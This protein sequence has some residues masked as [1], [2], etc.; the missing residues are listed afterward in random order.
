M[1]T[2]LQ[3]FFV[4]VLLIL[5][6][7]FVYRPKR[8]KGI[9][10]SRHYL[11]SVFNDHVKFYQLL[12]EEDKKRFEE[13]VQNFL[14]DIRITGVKTI[15]EDIDR[16]FIGAGAIIPVY[17]F[18]D[19]EYTNLHEI[20]LYPG[21]FSEEFEQEGYYRSISGMVGTG[22]MQNV[23]IISKADLRRSF[24]DNYGTRNTAIH[25]FVH[26][27]DKMDGTTDGIPEILL[28]RQNI[29]RWLYIM[30]ETIQQI[31]NGG[32]D[33]DMYGAT[34]QAEFFAVVSEYFFEQPE[35][36]K[37]NHPELFKTLEKIFIRK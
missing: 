27:I 7:L 1:V 34:S 8:I 14:I 21:I 13:K 22:A 10:L 24:I 4:L 17:S 31:K 15:V 16:V 9:I 11:R 2:T 18:R 26:L 32:S 19:W 6:I 36:L 3:I 20:L 12:D 25:E 29:N 5:L 23:M 33:I 37:I 35:M 28:E 30:N